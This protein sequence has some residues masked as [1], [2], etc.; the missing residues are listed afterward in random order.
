[1]AGDRPIALENVELHPFLVGKDFKRAQ[2]A[3]PAGFTSHSAKKANDLV[4]LRGTD[5]AG[6]NRAQP[7]RSQLEI[8]QLAAV[9]VKLRAIAITPRLRGYDFDL[10]G[11][12]YLTDAP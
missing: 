4:D 8:S 2:E 7:V 11:W 1:M 6:C 3:G 5:W 9:H 10:L 12:L